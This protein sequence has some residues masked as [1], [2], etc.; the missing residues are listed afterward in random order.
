MKETNR[1]YLQPLLKYLRYPERHRA[2]RE[3]PHVDMMSLIGGNRNQLTI[4]EHRRYQRQVIEMPGPCR[5]RRIQ[6]NGVPRLQLIERILR[7]RSQNSRMHR[8][9]MQRRA[10]L[11]LRYDHHLPRTRI[12]RPGRIPPIL[13]VRRITGADQRRNHLVRYRV[14]PIPHHLQG[15]WIYLPS[16]HIAASQYARIPC[17]A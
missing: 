16:R 5:I 10:Y 4:E 13:D 14:E 8:P 3:P 15:D 6:R 1:R 2:R 9:K 7:H 17:I 11:A 12:D